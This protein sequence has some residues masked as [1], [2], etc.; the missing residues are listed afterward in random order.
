MIR[1]RNRSSS[2]VKRV[3]VEFGRPV[4]SPHSILPRLTRA[5]SR[6]GSQ[7]RAFSHRNDGR[8]SG[9]RASSDISPFLVSLFTQVSDLWPT[10]APSASISSLFPVATFLGEGT[11]SISGFV[12]DTGILIFG[13]IRRAT[14]Q[15]DWKKAEFGFGIRKLKV[16]TPIT[17]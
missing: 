6:S 3:I 10:F 2:R 16:R 15:L 1:G 9:I 13:A 17:D 5:V 7:K 11:P 12:A 14:D 8:L 4:E